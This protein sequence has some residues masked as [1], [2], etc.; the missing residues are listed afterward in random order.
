MESEDGYGGADGGAA[1]LITQVPRRPTFELEER[2]ETEEDFD[3]LVDYIS[4]ELEGKK[5]LEKPRVSKKTMLFALQ[6]QASLIKILKKDAG[7]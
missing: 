7:R 2:P 3:G 1:T 4:R 6:K 5:I